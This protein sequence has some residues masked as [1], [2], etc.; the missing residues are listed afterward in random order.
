[1]KRKPEWLKIKVMGNSVNEEVENLI[2]NN[3][4][5]TVCHEANCPNKMECYKRGTATFMIMGSICTRNCKFCN[6]ETRKPLPLDA[7]EPMNVAKAV[8]HLKLR[9]AVIT[10]PD[11]DD[12]PDEGAEHFRQVALAIKELN[13]DTTVELLIPDFHA[14]H[15]LLDIVF[16]SEPDVLNHNLEVVEDLHKF[17]CPQSNFENSIEVLR[18]AKEKGFATKTGIMLGLGETRE[19]VLDL[20]KKLRAVD[21]DMITIGQYLQPSKRHIEVSEYVH[22]DIFMELGDIAKEMGFK[23]VNSSPF[24]RSSYHAEALNEEEKVAVGT[25]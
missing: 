6:V 24:V 22:P 3:H 5:H 19:Q 10:S 12:L 23:R 11:R 8:K 2:K 20:F 14:K 15:D 4:L 25:V 9:H 13:P 1:M 18:Y 21:V 17:I 16:S 7:E